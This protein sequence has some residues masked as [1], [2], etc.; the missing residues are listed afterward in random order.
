MEHDGKCPSILFLEQK[1]TKTAHERCAVLLAVNPEQEQQRYQLLK[2]KDT[3]SQAQERLHG[4]AVTA[5]HG[6]GAGT[7]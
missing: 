7:L 3:L 4:L 5:A 6:S 1:L 2:E